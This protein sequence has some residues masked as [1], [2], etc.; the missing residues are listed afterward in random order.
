MIDKSYILSKDIYFDSNDEFFDV[1]K[2]ANSNDDFEEVKPEWHYENVF[3][4][5]ERWFR[6]RPTQETYLL[7]D[8]DPPIFGYW[9][10]I[11]PSSPPKESEED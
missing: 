5:V 8:S 4:S 6:Y 7:V 1:F 11:D 3:G 9:I 10:K 2:I